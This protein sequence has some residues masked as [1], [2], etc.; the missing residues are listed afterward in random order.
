V[1]GFFTPLLDWIKNAV[2]YEFI[3]ANNA[4]ICVEAKSVDEVMEK[5]VNYKLPDDRYRLDWTIQ[6]PLETKSL[7]SNGVR[8]KSIAEESI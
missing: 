8:E 1:K 6:S 5:L 2:H 4:N 7:Q 3:K